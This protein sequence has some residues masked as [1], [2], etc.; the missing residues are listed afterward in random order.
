MEQGD[1]FF[2]GN[3]ARSMCD[4]SQGIHHL[5]DINAVGAPGAAGMAGSAEPYGF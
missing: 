5:G 4:A 2:S 3:S 1:I